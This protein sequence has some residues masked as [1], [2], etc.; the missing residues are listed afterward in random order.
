MH[1]KYVYIR[2]DPGATSCIYNWQLGVL[3]R[4]I[5]RNSHSFP[6]LITKTSDVQHYRIAWDRSQRKTSLLNRKIL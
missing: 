2:F 3:S 1:Q 5:R 4:C 6:Q